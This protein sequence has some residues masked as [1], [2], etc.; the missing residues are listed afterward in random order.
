M[1]ER[2][3]VGKLITKLAGNGFAPKKEM[4]ELICGV[5]VAIVDRIHNRQAR[6]R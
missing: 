6:A 1:Q 2:L 3:L 5:R 4:R